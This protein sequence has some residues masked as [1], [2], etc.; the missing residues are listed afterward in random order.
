MSAFFESVFS[1]ILSLPL[2]LAAFLFVL[3]IVV[4]V[5]E[6]GHLAVGRAFGIKADVFSLGFGKCLWS[7]MDRRGTEWRICLIPLGGYVKFRGDRNASSQASHELLSAMS[8]AERKGTFF[9]AS[10]IARACTIAAGPMINIAFAALVFGIVSL[11]QGEAVLLTKIGAITQNT[12]AERA[13]I[14][15]GDV[16]V[17]VNGMRTPGAEEV[18]AEVEKN[19]DAPMVMTISRGTEK[20][21]FNLTPIVK[22]R[23][24]AGGVETYIMVGVAFDTTEGN[25]T[26]KPM[27]IASAAWSGVSITYKVAA[28]TYE[29][30]HR[31]VTGQD[32]VENLSG[33]VRIAAISGDVAENHGILGLVQLMGIISVSI[34]LMNLLP[35]PIL[36]GGHLVLFAY[37]A[38]AKRRPNK[39]VEQFGYGVGL[40]CVLSL[41]VF[42][43]FN[44]I[45]QLAF[46]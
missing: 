39:K 17:A 21:D 11:Y 3:G 19:R 45:V 38:V 37:E 35:I 26:Y 23:P 29:A 46:R 30:L 42:A 41:M 33:P 16:V 36:D 28:L 27:S 7:R 13:G 5:H 22:T 44:D 8:D 31:I 12:P 4:A 43:T 15:A 32:G 10:L 1:T 18:V 34:G 40:A 20:L 24:T 6:Y 25:I 9:D 14:K 2:I